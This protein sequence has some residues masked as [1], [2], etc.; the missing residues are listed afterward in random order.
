LNAGKKEDR[1]GGQEEKKGRTHVPPQNDQNEGDHHQESRPNEFH[2]PI[3][4]LDREVVR[5][6][7]CQH[8]HEGQLG[9][10]RRL[11]GERTDFEP[12][13]ISRHRLTEEKDEEQQEQT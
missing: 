1:G 9:K 12:A 3:G 11:K 13:Q 8:K 5:K 7:T 4:T 6:M 10:F 2:Q